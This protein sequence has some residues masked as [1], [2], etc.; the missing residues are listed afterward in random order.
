MENW[1]RRREVARNTD[2]L[3]GDVT[4]PPVQH[5]NNTNTIHTGGRGAEHP[6]GMLGWAWGANTP[7]AY[8]D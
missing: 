1:V 8:G 3:C 6:T 7:H 4:C 5:T 2:A